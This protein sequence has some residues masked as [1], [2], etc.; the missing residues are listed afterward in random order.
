MAYSIFGARNSV[1]A[2]KNAQRYFGKKRTVTSVKRFSTKKASN[3]TYGYTVR[4]RK[5]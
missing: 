1:T 2:R 4:T 3:G 5:N